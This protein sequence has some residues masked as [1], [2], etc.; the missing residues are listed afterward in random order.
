MAITVNAVKCPSCGAD[1]P[2]EEGREKIFCSFCG[3]PIVITNENEHIYRHIDEA[4][5]KQAETDRMI[6]LKELE[7]E[8]AKYKQSSSLRSLLI[9]IWIGAIFAVAILCLV[10]WLRDDELG[11]LMAFNCLFYVGGPVVGGGAYLIFKLIPE[12]ENEKN[13]RREGGIKFPKNLEPFDEKNY[14]EVEKALRRVGFNN[15]SCINMHDLTIGLLTKPG[16][17]ESISVDDVQITS[18]GKYYMPSVPI[19]ITYHGK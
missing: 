12:K 5:I 6:R 15:I 2:V 16:K 14:A 11:G 9:K 17:I 3:T 18:G 4:G 1:L 8:E 7:I 10:V 13:I 19:T